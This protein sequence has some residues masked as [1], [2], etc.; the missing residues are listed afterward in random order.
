MNRD[1]IIFYFRSLRMLFVFLIV[2]QLAAC[3]VAIYLLQT[4]TTISTGVAS[5][6]LMF[7]IALPVFVASGG[8]G[9]SRKELQKAFKV[10]GVAKKLKLYRKS[11]IIAWSFIA[12]AGV[13]VAVL[14]L[15][16][17]MYW[18][19]AAPGLFLVFFATTITNPI[20]A[21]KQLKLTRGEL[22]ELQS[23]YKNIQGT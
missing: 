2:V 11:L 6:T 22:A 23:Y 9:L 16:T 10:W 15:M 1:E 17:Q 18:M 13:L 12:V 3:G 5:D 21:A 14:L 8:I 19:L 20:K 7:G 4:G